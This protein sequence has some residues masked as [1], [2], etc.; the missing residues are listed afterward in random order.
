MTEPI[1]VRTPTL[2][3]VPGKPLGRQRLLNWRDVARHLPVREGL[4]LRSVT[5]AP[6]VAA[7]LDQGEL[8]ACTG[9][10]AGGCA[11]T[12]PYGH[13]LTNAQCIELY[14]RATQLDPFPGT[15]PPVDTGSS[16]WAAMTAACEVGYFDRF[17]MTAGLTA[18]LQA[19]QTRPVIL[20]LDWY[21][22]F[23][24][25]EPDGRIRLTSS[26]QL[27]GG[28]EIKAD[29]VDVENGLVWVRNSWGLWGVEHRGLWGYGYF[30]FRDLA[31]LLESG[32]DACAPEMP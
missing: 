25:T 20:G 26:C 8:G 5:H 15:Y 28:H 29:E 2:I 3:E 22:T 21:S 32:G 12:E 14:K 17:A 10:A 1:V 31:L 13:R 6:N 7:P 16:G 23:D 19:L 11:S 30:T 27:R 9:F 24:D 4:E 18:V